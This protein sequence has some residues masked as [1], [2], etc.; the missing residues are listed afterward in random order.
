MLVA[1]DSSLFA[2]NPHL[3]STPQ[4]HVVGRSR[5][6]PR[7]TPRLSGDNPPPSLNTPSAC[8]GQVPLHAF[9]WASPPVTT[10]CPISFALAR[11]GVAQHCR[12]T[13]TC[14]CLAPPLPTSQVP[15]LPSMLPAPSSSTAQSRGRIPSLQGA[16]LSRCSHISSPSQARNHKSSCLAQPASRLGLMEACKCS[17]LKQAPSSL[18]AASLCS[19]SPQS[20][21]FLPFPARQL[22]WPARRTTG[23]SSSRTSSRGRAL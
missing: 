13:A 23:L 3:P 4:A 5:F 10:S 11:G 18:Q 17:H 19:S 2:P 20:Q 15:S 14:S 9:L 8:R 6:M 16:R 1:G 21:V 22:S 12:D 7:V